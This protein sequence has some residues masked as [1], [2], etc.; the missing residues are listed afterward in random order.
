LAAGLLERGFSFWD[1]SGSERYVYQEGAIKA[2]AFSPDNRWLVTVSDQQT[3]KLWELATGK[4]ARTFT[5]TGHAERVTSVAFSPD[6]RWLAS[7]SEDHTIEL[8][9]VTTG[10][11]VRT[12]VGHTDNVNSVA[13]SPDGRWLAS[14]SDDHTI[15]LWEVATDTPAR[16]LAGHTD[17]VRSVA[18]SPDGRWLASG[19]K[20]HTIRLWDVVTGRE[21]R[22]LEARTLEVHVVAFGRDGQSVGYVGRLGDGLLGEQFWDTSTGNEVNPPA[23]QGEA[24][25]A[26]VQPGAK[27]R[28]VQ[29]MQ[30]YY[31][32]VG[33]ISSDGRWLASERGNTIKLGEVATGRAVRTF[34]G[35]QKDVTSVVF[36]PDGRWLASGSKDHTI[37]LWDVVT[38]REVRTLVGHSDIVWTLAFSSDSGLLVSGSEDNTVRLWDVTTGRELHTLWGHTGKVLSVAFS[39]DR[40][41]VASASGWSIGEKKDRTVR[42]WD[43]ATGQQIRILGEHEY[44]ILALAFSPD[45]RWLVSG[46]TSRERIG[47][48]KLWDP[49]SGRLHRTIPGDI[50]NAVAFTPD[51][52]WLWYA[53]GKWG[54]RGTV[55]LVEVESGR[56]ARMLQGY[57]EEDLFSPTGQLLSTGEAVWDLSS[58]LGTGAV[59]FAQLDS[60]RASL[61]LRCA[62]TAASNSEEKPVLVPQTGFRVEYIGSGF[63][64]VAFSPDSCL[65]AAADDDGVKIWD[66][67]T[68]LQLRTLPAD[69]PLAFSPD[70]R[71]LAVS[72]RENNMTP[73]SSDGRYLATGWSEVQLWEIAAGRK[74]R[75]LRL[76]TEPMTL[77]RGLRSSNPLGTLVFTP[78]SRWL[79]YLTRLKEFSSSYSYAIVRWNLSTGE[80]TAIK[81]DWKGETDFDWALSAD[82]RYMAGTTALSPDQWE[83]KIWKVATGQE[84]RS[85]AIEAYT[86]PLALSPDGSIVADA[87]HPIKLWEVETGR[88]LRTVDTGDLGYAIEDLTFSPDGH[89]LA[90]S[91]SNNVVKVWDV[92]TARTMLTLQIEAA[93]GI[94]LAF[95]EDSRQLAVHGVPW[96]LATG[97]QAYPHHRGYRGRWDAHWRLAAT[98]GDESG[99]PTPG[100]EDSLDV[101]DVPSG[102]QLYSLGRRTMPLEVVAFSP[103]GRWLVMDPKFVRTY[104]GPTGKDL[105]PRV[106]EV[107]TGRL[108]RRLPLLKQSDEEVGLSFTSDGRWL[109]KGIRGESLNVWDIATGEEL[110]TPRLGTEQLFQEWYSGLEHTSPDRSVRTSAS[111]DGTVIILD[112]ATSQELARVIPMRMSDEWLVVAPDGLFDGSPAGVQELVAWRSGNTAMP[113]EVFFNDFYYPGLLADILA[114]KR[115]RAQR[116]IANL[117][118]RQPVVKLELGGGQSSSASLESRTVKLKLEVAEAPA[119]QAHPRGSGARDVRLF[120]NGSLVRVWRGELSLD[121]R[122]KAVLEATIPIVWGGNRLTAYAFNRDNVKSF[123]ALLDLTGAGNLRRKGTAYILAIGINEYANPGY[124]LKYAVADAQDFAEELRSQQTKLNAFA[125]VEVIS[126]LDKDATKATLLAAFGRLAG[127]TKPLPLNAAPALAKLKPAEPEDAV[128]VYYA[129]HGTAAGPRF[130]LIPH[131][132]GYAGSRAELDEAGLKTVLEHS[133]SDRELEQAFEKIDAGRLLLVIDACNSGQALE[134]EEKRRGPM[135]SKGLAQLAY[136]KGMYVLTA[137][138]GYQAAQ[139]AAQLGHGFLTYALVEE[140][141]KTA[142]ADN[143][144]QDGQVILR[145]WLDYATLRVPQM[146]EKMMLDARKLGREIPIVDGEE[147]IRELARRS[148]QRPRVFYRREPEAQPLVIAKPEAK[149]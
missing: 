60:L 22:S 47:E 83:I 100:G 61:R 90:A 91:G 81:V 84:V 66:L 89:L 111:K 129:G 56:E 78:D 125:T 23:C 74:V 48:L 6:G 63:E 8:W 50:A 106:W 26:S 116:N 147:K 149:P 140:G 145:E 72:S 33:A 68:G 30:N 136:E 110:P 117:D 59:G 57:G 109:A 51:G 134:A 16:T 7:G 20:D 42:L 132:L 28:L 53:E 148:L 142:A 87:G 49:A 124:N 17:E 121:N 2:L 139:E 101:W 130:Y 92:A 31:G 75:E 43:V 79:I 114:G 118:R 119:D 39:P 137:S 14:G 21:L 103:D 131:D 32:Q 70:G 15:K 58:V 1:S 127:D 18:F 99:L 69:Y 95:S 123:N 77:Q 122:G 98:R 11:E 10:R 44:E 86:S 25:S 9:E 5:G 135:N 138:Q 4:E 105:S 27:P 38:G 19:S 141:L 82:G 41:W 67:A 52:R 62:Q 46:S 37:K 80:H 88:E 29:L 45:G 107:S 104:Q 146:Q 96:D 24:P 85:I 144:P 113:L 126:L 128:F 12:F 13:F 76:A 36:S 108:L 115:P 93:L 73:L 34:A 97:S 3:F 65:L 35:H 102:L 120:R 94:G 64:Q 133:I 54:H 143:A 71:W 40:R 55:H 112:N